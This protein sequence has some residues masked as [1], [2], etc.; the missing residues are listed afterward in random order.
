MWSR[1]KLKDHAKLFLKQHYLTAFVVCLIA[2]ILGGSSQSPSILNRVTPD[3]GD[4]TQVIE[5][6]RDPAFWSHL[7]RGLRLFL[8]SIYGI[9]S[10][11]FGL[12]FLALKLVVGNNMRIGRSRYFINAIEGDS[13]L[14]YLFSTFKRGEWMDMTVKMFI[15]D[16]IIFLWSLLLVIPGI[17]KS[18]QYKFVPYILAQNPQMSITQAMAVSTTM[19]D[20]DKLNLFVLDLSFIGWQIL[21]GLLFGIGGIL[22]EPYIKATEA[23]LYRL[24]EVNPSILGE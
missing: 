3:F 17:I 20:K 19:T 22:V 11:G 9:I 1:A 4:A 2:I 8:R 23:T 15:L 7:A 6:M 14:D 5:P 18:Y 13:Q 21:G 16:A 24:K 12:F 10:I